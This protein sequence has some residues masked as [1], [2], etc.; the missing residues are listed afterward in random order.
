M[1]I[2]LYTKNEY[3]VI[4]QL[5]PKKGRKEGWKGGREGEKGCMQLLPALGPNFGFVDILVHGE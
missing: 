3:N 2:K 5:Y 1:I 4:C